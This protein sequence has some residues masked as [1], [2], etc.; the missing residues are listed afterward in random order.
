METTNVKNVFLLGASLEV[1]HQESLEWLDIVEF[2]KDEVVFFKKLLGKKQP[3]DEDR[4]MYANLVS[5]LGDISMELL[6]E[7]E[8]DIRQHER[9]LAKLM[10]EDKGVSDGEYRESHQRLKNR[11]EKINSSLKAFKK[12]LF[13]FVKSL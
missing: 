13:S 11:I 4:E 8:E 10:E 5:T 3:S 12:Q 6:N 1:L 2:W 9:L 7:L